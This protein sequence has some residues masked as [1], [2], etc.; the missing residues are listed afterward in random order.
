MYLSEHDIINHTVKRKHRSRVKRLYVPNEV[1]L[2]CGWPSRGLQRRVSQIG[3]CCFCRRLP[4]VSSVSLT[5]LHFLSAKA[6]VSCLKS[7]NYLCIML[8]NGKFMLWNL[9]PAFALK[10]AMCN[11]RC[12][13]QIKWASELKGFYLK[14]KTWQLS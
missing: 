4:C 12:K 10:N 5:T 7:E 3:L 11:N 8:Q 13:S 2:A 1:I 6:E 14:M 9:N